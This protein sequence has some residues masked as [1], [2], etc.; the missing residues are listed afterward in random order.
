M[1]INPSPRPK[2]Q[3]KDARKDEKR[4]AYLLPPHLYLFIYL[5]TY[6]FIYLFTY[7]LIYQF[8]YLLIDQFLKILPLKFDFA[9]PLP[10]I[11]TAERLILN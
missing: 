6:L 11:D 3:H 4:V 1:Q 8:I 5:F 9:F 2:R 10:H 7:L